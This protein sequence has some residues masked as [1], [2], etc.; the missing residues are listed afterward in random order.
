METGGVKVY[1]AD[2]NRG[3]YMLVIFFREKNHLIQIHSA[4]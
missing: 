4:V 2:N 1:K 3:E